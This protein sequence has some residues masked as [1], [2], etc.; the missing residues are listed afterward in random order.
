[1]CAGVHASADLFVLT[2][3][4]R[5][6]ESERAS[7]Q[8]REQAAE[9]IRDHYAA[10]RLTDD[11]L[12][13]RV[14]AAYAA[15]TTGELQRLLADL[16]VLPEVRRRQE[17]AELVERRTHLQRR[18]LQ[19]AGGS[20][21]A[22]AVCTGI[23][24]ATGASGSFWPIWIALIAVIGLLKSGWDLYGPAPTSTP[25]KS[26]STRSAIAAGNEISVTF[27]A[28]SSASS[29]GSTGP[30]DAV[31]AEKVAATVALHGHRPFR[32]A[33]PASRCNP[34]AAQV[35]CGLSLTPLR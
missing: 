19:Q 20:V 31:A 28:M 1:M 17:R 7:D 15:Q 21:I 11:E 30:I 23:W 4:S 35:A 13:T 5:A 3:D 2:L 33:V 14:Q 27:S 29:A 18:L 25:S 22:F 8:D 10:G 12:D 6:M 34:R 9:Q 24:A 32:A 26:A 16:P